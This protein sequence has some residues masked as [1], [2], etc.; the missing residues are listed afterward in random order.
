MASRLQLRS[1][2]T[3]RVTDA[4][5]NFDEEQ[6]QAAEAKDLQQQYDSSPSLLN[7]SANDLAKPIESGQ[8]LSLLNKA[9]DFMSQPGMSSAVSGAATMV[10]GTIDPEGSGM[11]PVL[12]GAGQG[13]AIGTTVFPGIGTAVGAAIG[14]GLG[15]IQAENKRKEIKRQAEAKAKGIMAQGLENAAKAT[16]R[17][18]VRESFAAKRRLKL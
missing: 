6:K 11:G 5:W 18:M 13:A 12:S 10:G 7:H 17:G 14:A 9:G 3:P 15:M 2:R 16:E 4:R 1:Q 8:K